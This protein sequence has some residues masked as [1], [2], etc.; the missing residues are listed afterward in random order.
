[1]CICVWTSIYVYEHFCYV[2]VLCVYVFVLKTNT[3]IFVY[4]ILYPQTYIYTQPIH[5]LYP[6]YTVAKTPGGNL[7]FEAAPFK[8]TA[9]MV[10]LMGG[11]NRSVGQYRG[12]GVY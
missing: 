6:A 11:V 12:A 7:A 4:N 3:I 8:L 2:A 1:M 9:E 5:I 10:E